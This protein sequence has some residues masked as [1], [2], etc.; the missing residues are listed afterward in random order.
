MLLFYGLVYTIR[1][2]LAKKEIKGPYCNSC[3]I[4]DLHMYHAS[5]EDAYNLEQVVFII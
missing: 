3:N 4:F 2:S 5:L 1:F